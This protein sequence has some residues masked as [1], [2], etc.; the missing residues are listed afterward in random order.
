MGN[1]NCNNNLEFM[2]NCYSV[3]NSAARLYSHYGLYDHHIYDQIQKVIVK[4]IT[5]VMNYEG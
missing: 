3:G 2:E 5:I 4:V 1:E